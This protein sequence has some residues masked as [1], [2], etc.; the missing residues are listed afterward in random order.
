M[1]SREK[2]SNIYTFNHFTS[3]L[4]TSFP[5]QICFSEVFVPKQCFLSSFCHLLPTLLFP[6]SLCSSLYLVL[7]MVFVLTDHFLS[8]FFRVYTKLLRPLPNLRWDSA[9]ASPL[10]GSGD[11][12]LHAGAPKRAGQGDEPGGLTQLVRQIGL[13]RNQS[14]WWEAGKK[15]RVQWPL[16]V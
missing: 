5:I 12:C 15:S 11:I 7:D 3:K 16:S 4:W 8:S 13:Q 1:T 9:T 6:S 10:D 14:L 2:K